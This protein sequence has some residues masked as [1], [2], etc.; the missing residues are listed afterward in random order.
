MAKTQDPRREQYDQARAAFEELSIEDRVLFL[1]K[2]TIT[3]V[4][5]GIER[6]GRTVAEELDA[7]FEERESKSEDG[8]AASE[9]E[10]KS[11]SKTAKKSS[12]RAKKSTSKKTAAKKGTAATK[13]E[14]EGE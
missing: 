12:T 13:D 11:T 9:A 7:L 4:A 10:P 2:E 14:E 8:E 6:A 5:D 1:L 3:T